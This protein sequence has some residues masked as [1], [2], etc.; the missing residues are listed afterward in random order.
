[1]RSMGRVRGVTE[2]SASSF[3]T[4]T[5]NYPPPVCAPGSGLGTH[6]SG[7]H[8]SRTFVQGHIGHLLVLYMVALVLKRSYSFLIIELCLLGCM[9]HE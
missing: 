4:C 2:V 5:R 6:R 3:C 9:E 8:S 1:V 7:T